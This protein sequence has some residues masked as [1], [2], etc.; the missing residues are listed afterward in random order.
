MMTAAVTG[1]VPP[2]QHSPVIHNAS[3]AERSP[4]RGESR[5]APAPG[6]ATAT[7]SPLPH[8]RGLGT[9]GTVAQ[10]GLGGER[11]GWRDARREQV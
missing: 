4:R 9:A 3:G 6:R 11:R 5:G 8:R 2:L 1:V 7:Q 10:E